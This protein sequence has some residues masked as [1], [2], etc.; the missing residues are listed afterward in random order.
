MAPRQ[1]TLPE[2]AVLGGQV[3]VLSLQGILPEGVLQD[4]LP[5][6]PLGNRARHGSLGDPALTQCDI[7]PAPQCHLWSCFMSL[8]KEE[9]NPP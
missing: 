4:S 8:F 2:A 3:G 9:I 5:R 7:L 1:G 6:Q